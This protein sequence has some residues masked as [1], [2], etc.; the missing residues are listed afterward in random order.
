ML[1]QENREC[2]GIGTA[3]ARGNP[4]HLVYIRETAQLGRA[5]AVVMLQIIKVGL[6]LT[7]IFIHFRLAD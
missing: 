1:G 6:R 2:S 7:D 4:H 5:I 3:D